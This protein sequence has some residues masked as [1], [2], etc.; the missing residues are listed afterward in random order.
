MFLLSE[1]RQITNPL[2]RQIFGVGQCELETY[3][4]GLLLSTQNA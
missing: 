3:C 2:V 1:G 4:C